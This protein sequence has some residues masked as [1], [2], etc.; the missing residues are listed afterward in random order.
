V[1]CP[2][3]PAGSGQAGNI[4]NPVLEERVNFERSVMGSVKGEAEKLLKCV[5]QA[6]RLRMQEYF[7]SISELE[8]KFRI[9]TAQPE[10]GPTPAPGGGA[11]AASCGMPNP[12]TG[13]PGITLKAG[14]R[15]CSTCW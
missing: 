3:G 10:P 5:G 8:R 9:P 14:S 11:S 6:D 2:A 4:P 1:T 15:R 7:N 13:D 12:V